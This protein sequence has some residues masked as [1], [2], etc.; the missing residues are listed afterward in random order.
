VEDVFAAIDLETNRAEGL[1]FDPGLQVA[2]EHSEIG[3]VLSEPCGHDVVRAARP[4][5]SA[6]AGV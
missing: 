5:T 4:S 6:Q 1:L 3:G 2:K